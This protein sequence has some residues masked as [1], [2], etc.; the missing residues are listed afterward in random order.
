MYVTLRLIREGMSSE[1][2]ERDTYERVI[3]IPFVPQIGMILVLDE[4]VKYEVKGVGW[5]QSNGAVV[6]T[7]KSSFGRMS[8]DW[9][10]VD[11]LNG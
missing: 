6:V 1:G 5:I 2:W 8:G 4:N 9:K 3:E 7:V 11:F 10:K